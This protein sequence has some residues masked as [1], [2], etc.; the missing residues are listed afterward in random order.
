MSRRS[1][2]VIDLD[3]LRH[4]LVRVR[5]RAPRARVMAAVKAEAYGHGAVEVARALDADALA[6]ATLGEALELRQAGIG[7]PIVLLGGV[8]DT[9]ELHTATGQDLQLVVHDFHQLG[10]IERS[11]CAHTAAV[12]IKLDTGMHRLGFES[13][14]MPELCRRLAALPALRLQGWMTHFACADETD[15]PATCRQIETFRQMTAGLPGARSLANSAGILAWPDAHADWVRP[16]IML[17]G[18]SP[19]AGCSAE[20][21]GLRPVMTLRSRVLSIRELPAGEAVGYGGSWITPERMRVGILAIGYGDGYPRHAPSGT[22]VRVGG[23]RTQVVGRVSMDLLA[24]DLRGCDEVREGDEAVLWG[25]GLPADEVAAA[26]DTIAYELF[27]AVRRKRVEY[28]YAG[29]PNA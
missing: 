1:W 8:L 2:A 28:V 10:L 11:A 3:A 15:N 14:A 13:G 20:S 17:Y 5:E 18:A 27:C 6:V 12:W 19:L 16:G 23:R 7:R 26:A 4:N 24:V 25:E 29:R 21:L 22:P 9:D